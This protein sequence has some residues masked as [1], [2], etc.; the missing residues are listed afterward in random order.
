MRCHAFDSNLIF[1]TTL[2]FIRKVV[3]LTTG[4]K[5]KKDPE[6]GFGCD[7]FDLKLASFPCVVGNHHMV[8]I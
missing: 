3:D 6:T 4:E 8:E 7:P 5:V 1:R 2:D